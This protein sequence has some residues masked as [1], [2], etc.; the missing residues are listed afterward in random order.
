MVAHV[1]EKGLHISSLKKG[2]LYCYWKKVVYIV[3]EKGLYPSL[4]RGQVTC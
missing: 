1:T 3:T 2:S 4:E